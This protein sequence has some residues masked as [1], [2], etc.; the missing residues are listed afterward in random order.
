[1]AVEEEAVASGSVRA[2]VDSSTCLLE[3]GVAVSE[4]LVLG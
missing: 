3:G 2:D 4:I 1:M